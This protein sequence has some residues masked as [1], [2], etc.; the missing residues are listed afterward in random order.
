MQNL[1]VSL[2]ENVQNNHLVLTI[3]VHQ[4]RKNSQSLFILLL[5]RF[6]LGF[7]LNIATTDTDLHTTGNHTFP[8]S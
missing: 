2:Y 7:M 1:P 3:L 8:R 5:F 4:V 6:L